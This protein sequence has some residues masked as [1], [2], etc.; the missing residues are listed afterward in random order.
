M[1]AQSG[2]ASEMIYYDCRRVGAARP[3]HYE[4]RS[5]GPASCAVAGSLE[6]FLVE[7]YRLFACRNGTLYS[8]EVW[9]EPYTFTGAEVPQWCTN[10][11]RQAGFGN[12]S[13]P[14]DHAIF[15]TGVDVS[16][17]PL[18]RSETPL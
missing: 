1:R 18:L 5:I 14:P 4:Y 17:F 7:R 16:I 6:E 11:L 10:P 13:M 8:G 2:P 3:S 12:I 9:H 15:S